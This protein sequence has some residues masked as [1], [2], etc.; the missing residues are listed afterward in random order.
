MIKTGIDAEF[1]EY[2]E[3][4]AAAANMHKQAFEQQQHE[5]SNLH[6]NGDRARFMVKRAHQED[7]ADLAAAFAAE[8]QVY[9]TLDLADAI[10][11]IPNTGKR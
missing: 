9:A 7:R 3:K 6:T 5:L 11:R 1:R 10:R 2:V 4:Q 8:A